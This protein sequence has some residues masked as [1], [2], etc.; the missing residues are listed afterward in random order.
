MWEQRI[1]ERYPWAKIQDRLDEL[2]L[3]LSKAED[4]E[5]VEL[6]LLSLHFGNRIDLDFFT[7]REQQQI[8]KRLSTL[9]KD[10]RK[11]CELLARAVQE[12]KDKKTALRREE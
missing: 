11:H 6:S 4:E 5:D 9:I 2:L 12:I 10:T 7:K 3:E 8:K 1:R